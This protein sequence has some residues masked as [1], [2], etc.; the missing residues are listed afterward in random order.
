MR[1]TLI[2]ET[3]TFAKKDIE[4]VQSSLAKAF[5]TKEMKNYMKEG[6]GNGKRNIK[7]NQKRSRTN[8]R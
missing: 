7:R 8:G 3:K 1:I 4:Q 5:N 6:K 2:D